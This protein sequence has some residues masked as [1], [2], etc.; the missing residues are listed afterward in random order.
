MD[1]YSLIEFDKRNEELQNN[2]ERI[3]ND[4]KLFLWIGIIILFRMLIS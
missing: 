3:K 2:P 4:F 1:D